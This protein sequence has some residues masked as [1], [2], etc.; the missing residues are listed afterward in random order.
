MPDLRIHL[1]LSE[2]DFKGY[3][4][5]AKS[6]P[7]HLPSS[8]SPELRLRICSNQLIETERQLREAE[9]SDALESLRNRLRTKTFMS[10]YKAT[11]ISGQRGNTRARVLLATVDLRIFLL[12]HR[13]RRARVALMSLLGAEQWT[14][15]GLANKFRELRDEDVRGLGDAALKEA[16]KASVEY[17][18]QRAAAG[19]GG[20]PTLRVLEVHPEG[21]RTLSW[22][23]MSVSL[24]ADGSDPD[25]NDGM[26]SQS[27]FGLRNS[28][29]LHLKLFV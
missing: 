29:I 11:N 3:R 23:W 16:E 2:D 15:L 6:I 5:H 24:A 8:L 10:R 22:L 19:Q 9:A 14:Q 18:Q 28:L 7:L 1:N 25:L 20:L 12:K 13:Y 17:A 26:S 21:S 27:A 4:S